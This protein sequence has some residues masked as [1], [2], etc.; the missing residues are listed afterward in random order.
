MSLTGSPIGG[1]ALFQVLDLAFLSG[2]Q[3]NFLC[4]LI[5][6]LVSL[7]FGPRDT[8]VPCSI[9]AT[10]VNHRPTGTKD[11][12]LAESLSP[13]GLALELTGWIEGLDQIL[14]R[15]SK[16]WTTPQGPLQQRIRRE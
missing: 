16:L 11:R 2:L 7:E 1:G 3:L 13:Q 8:P 5:Y 12:V 4:F 10:K 9:L 6:W 15:L 14:L